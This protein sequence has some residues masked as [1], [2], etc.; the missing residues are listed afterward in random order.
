MAMPKNIKQF[1]ADMWIRIKRPVS[2]GCQI[3]MT[4]VLACLLFG[5]IPGMSWAYYNAQQPI[6]FWV[7]IVPVMFMLA[8]Y[9]V[10]RIAIKIMLAIEVDSKDAD[11]YNDGASEEIFKLNM[12]LS[13]QAGIYIAHRILSHYQL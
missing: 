13:A 2:I 7:G 6:Y 3:I 5:I 11:E 9:L 10:C 4:I 12:A 1:M 8:N